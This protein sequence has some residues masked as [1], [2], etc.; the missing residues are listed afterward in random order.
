MRLGDYSG[1][2]VVMLL[3]I[4]LQFLNEFGFSQN[5][6]FVLH[7][8]MACVHSIPTCAEFYLH[9]PFRNVMYCS[10]GKVHVMEQT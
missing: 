6:L 3:P 8:W 2:G 9:R 1:G 4:R 10:S 5:S 7:L